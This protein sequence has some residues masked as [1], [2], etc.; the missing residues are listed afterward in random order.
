MDN[1]MELED[2]Y[3]DD[4]LHGE[5]HENPIGDDDTHE[6]HAA[7]HANDSVSSLVDKLREKIHQYNVDDAHEVSF[8]SIYTDAE[9]DK[10]EHDVEMAESEVSARKSDVANWESKVSLN[11]T[12]EHKKN[13]DYANA[14]NHLN[15]AKSKYNAA[16]DSLNAAKA[17][18]NNAR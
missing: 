2:I 4:L 5:P 3:D 7:H 13:G 16:V 9:I 11:N 6:D 12:D 1:D 8:G 17:K 10:M 15:E 18:L 14:V